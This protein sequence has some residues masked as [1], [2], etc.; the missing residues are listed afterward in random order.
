M[1]RVI[2]IVGKVKDYTLSLSQWQRERMATFLKSKE[3]LYVQ[4]TMRQQGKPRSVDQN[5]YYHA[6]PVTILANEFG[7]DHD[8]MHEILREKF[9]PPQFI[10]FKGERMQVRKS[11]TKLNTLEF[12]EY[13]D[14][15]RRWAATD[16][17]IKIPLPHEDM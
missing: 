12:E 3:G 14:A 5:E 15:I 9:L 17:N 2:T 13:L 8:E 11:T 6:V 4:V 1:S 16:Y 7:Y 10:D